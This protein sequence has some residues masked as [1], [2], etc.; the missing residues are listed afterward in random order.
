MNNAPPLPRLAQ[1]RPILPNL[2]LSRSGLARRRPALRLAGPRPGRRALALAGLV[3]LLAL[4]LLLAWP[5]WLQLRGNYH[6]VLPGLA[7]RAAQPDGAA[8]RR[9][10]AQDGIRSVLNLRGAQPDAPWYRAE[11]AASAELGLVHADF[12]LSATRE[13]TPQRLAE[14]VALMRRLPPPV[15]IHCRSGADRTGLAAALYLAAIAGRPPAEAAGQLSLRYGHLGLAPL[16]RA[17][18]M[19]RAFADYG[20]RMPL[21]LAA[22]GPR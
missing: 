16:S 15:L 1:A 10:Q 18:A 22:A 3:A 14:L 5:A 19:D 17:V 13:P 21:R 8:L 4:A 2:S 12:G 20:R 11:I 7:Y 6:V 9:A